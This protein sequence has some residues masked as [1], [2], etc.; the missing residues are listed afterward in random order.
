MPLT[1]AQL[2]RIDANRAQAAIRRE[3]TRQNALWQQ[4]QPQPPQ[5]Q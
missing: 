5:P 4:Q 1:M 2:Q 3:A